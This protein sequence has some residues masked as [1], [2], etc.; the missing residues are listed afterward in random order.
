MLK[1]FFK[2]KITLLHRRF[3]IY[4]GPVQSTLPFSAIPAGSCLAF[5]LSEAK[6]LTFDI[7]GKKNSTPVSE[8][9]ALTAE[10]E[11]RGFQLFDTLDSIAAT[12]DLGGNVKVYPLRGDGSPATGSETGEDIL[13]D[14]SADPYTISVEVPGEARALRQRFKYF[15]P[16]R[17]D[18]V[19]GLEFLDSGVKYKV[20]SVVPIRG[21]PNFVSHLKV[22]V[23]REPYEL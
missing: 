23:S 2:T 3:E 5:T 15:F 1:P 11:N 18:I 20:E 22:V 17:D 12:G 7:T 4:D 19:E 14:K 10:V 16:N 6:T 9:V 21:F 8:S 13:V